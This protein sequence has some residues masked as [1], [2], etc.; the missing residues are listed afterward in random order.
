M[1]VKK[2]PK[3]D[4]EKDVILSVL[5]GLLVSISVVFVALQW[6]S[7]SGDDN[8]KIQKLD[9]ADLDQQILVPDEE[10]PEDP[11]PPEPE[12]KQQIEA[13]LPE[14][15]KVVDNEK[16]VQQIKF[17]SNDENKPLPP[18]P[19]APVEEEKADEIFTIVEQDP[20]FT[21]GD[22]N[23]WLSSHL[24]YPEIAAESGIQGRVFLQFV[25]EKDGSAT[26]VKVV[27]GVDPSLDKE[28]VRVVKMMP[29]WK[30]GMQRGKPVRYRYT[31]PV[32]FRLN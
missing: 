13:Q 14:E 27:R 30:P 23:K 1:E 3:A 20:E 12:V 18:P 5:F 22:I 7:K 21:G 26:D 32:V 29:K 4:L 2:S 16:K 15:F 11:K 9:I 8:F 25:I 31:L 24:Q 28:A 6:K 10:K 19:P 17:V